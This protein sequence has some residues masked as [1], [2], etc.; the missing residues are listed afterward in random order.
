MSNYIFL[1]LSPIGT[2]KFALFV[3][4]LMGMLVGQLLDTILFIMV[5]FYGTVGMGSVILGQYFVKIAF[6]LIAAPLV[7]FGVWI[8]RSW[9]KT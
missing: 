5:A 1:A 4:A 8:G 9:L 7:S 3:R 6:A 2:G